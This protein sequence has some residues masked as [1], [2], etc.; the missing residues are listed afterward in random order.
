VIKKLMVMATMLAMMLVMAV[1]AWADDLNFG[2]DDLVFGFPG[3]NVVD[4]V[5]FENVRERTSK[6]WE[7]I[8]VDVDLDGFV[9]EWEITCYV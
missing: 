1:P 3:I 5:E 4:N 6:D 2:D 8:A 7:C 9:A